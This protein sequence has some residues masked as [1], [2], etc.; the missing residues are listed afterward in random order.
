LSDDELEQRA[1]A[2]L[3]SGYGT[4]LADIVRRQRQSALNLVS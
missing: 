4:Y 1:H 3:K 2:L